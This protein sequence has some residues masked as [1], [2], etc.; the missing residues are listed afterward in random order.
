V[1]QDTFN[2]RWNAVR[3]QFPG[4]ETGIY[5]DVSARSLLFER[6]R[7]AL[8]SHLDELS[9]GEVEK[10]LLFETVEA[11]RKLFARLIRSSPDE[12][13]FTRN[14]TDGIAA[15]GASI[16]WKSGDNV[17]LCEEL[18]HPANV[19]PWFG[20]SRRFGIT[21]KTV[22][23]EGG[24]VSVDHILSAIDANTRVVAISAI[25]FAPGFTFAV[26]DLGEECRRRGVLL[27]VDA[28]QSIGIADIDVAA[29]KA[30][31]I[32]AS[33]QKG[34]MSLY[35]LGFLYVRG[36][37]AEMLRPAYLSRFGTDQDGH[38]AGLGEP[39][40]DAY[41]RGARRFDVGN[42]NYPG[43]V[44]VGPAIQLLL[45]IGQANVEAYVFNLAKQFTNRIL[46]LGLPVFGGRPGRHSSH[47]VTVGAALG[48][49]HDATGDRN[50]LSLYEHLRDNKVRLSIRR[51]LLRFSFHIYNNESDIETVLKHVIGWMQREKA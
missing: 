5:L 18:E 40:T 44:T 25:S 49:D 30:D 39:E 24:A 12:V 51:N 27:L 42:Y 4:T 16:E 10:A 17:V 20:L 8:S 19:Y 38:E 26:S 35:G 33:T 50:M 43:I 37:I 13:S 3:A 1:T 14:V 15:F 6:G 21:I 41:A 9:A 2:N 45:E 7:A 23:S 34:L 36:E 28:A 11:T 47:I 29:W 48:V 31:A 46:D 22:S 32:V